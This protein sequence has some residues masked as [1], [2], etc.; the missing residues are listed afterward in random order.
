MSWASHNPELYDLITRKGIVA[1]LQYAL[2]KDGF[3]ETLEAFVEMIQQ[4]THFRRVYTELRDMSI[5]K[6]QEAEQQY[7]AELADKVKEDHN[8]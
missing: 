8:G 5:G 6:I 7:F 2:Y 4:D 1:H 3:E